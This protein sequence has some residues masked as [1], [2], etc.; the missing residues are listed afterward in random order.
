MS[1]KNIGVQDFISMEVFSSGIFMFTNVETLY[2]GKI[3]KFSAES[4]TV[5]TK[6]QRI[7]ELEGN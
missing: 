2:K 5:L 4:I 6:N 1:S 7:Y 3:G